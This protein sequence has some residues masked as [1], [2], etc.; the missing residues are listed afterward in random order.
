MQENTVIMRM[1]LSEEMSKGGEVS[2][3][4]APFFGLD[5]D[6]KEWHT[7]VKARCFGP[8]R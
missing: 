5:G 3:K 7:K 6:W 1:A 4:T 8:R 2:I